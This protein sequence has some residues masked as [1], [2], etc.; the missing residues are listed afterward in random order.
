MPI[1]FP[2]SGDNH[3]WNDWGQPRNGGRTH[4]G[5]DI[6]AK[7][8]VPV[9]AA[10][11]GK[12]RVHPI[13]PTN[14]NTFGG[15]SATVTTDDGTYYYYAH[16]SAFQ[17]GDRDVLAGE[18]IGFVGDTGNA[19]GTTPHLHF[20]VHPG[21]DGPVNPYPI[22]LAANR[23]TP[24]VYVRPA[25]SSDGSSVFVA[26]GVLAVTALGIVGLRSLSTPRSQARH[27]RGVAREAMP[28]YFP[29]R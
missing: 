21:G 6:F 22:L 10:A 11:S 13:G 5:T 18:V 12:L 27:A 8:G 25:A 26:L 2:V 15:N 20:E 28:R 4:Q 9:V 23:S 29:F 14:P 16:L 24:P 17:G 7:I 19:K 1:V 3:F